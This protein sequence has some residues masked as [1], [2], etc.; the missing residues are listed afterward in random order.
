MYIGTEIEFSCMVG[1]RHI[2][3]MT[4]KS[5][6]HSLLFFPFPNL[7]FTDI[8]LERVIRLVK[9]LVGSAMGHLMRKNISACMSRELM[10]I[11]V[12]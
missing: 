9:N 11:N 5:L 4:N 12:Y 7:Y 10:L 8:F 3:W 2:L 6:R 1:N